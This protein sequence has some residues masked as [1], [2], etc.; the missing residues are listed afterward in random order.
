MDRCSSN[1]LTSRTP[2]FFLVLLNGPRRSRSST[3][4]ITTYTPTNRIG[5]LFAIVGCQCRQSVVTFAQSLPQ[6]IEM[7]SVS[8][9]KKSAVRSLELS[10]AA[11]SGV[12]RQANGLSW[13]VI[14]FALDVGLFI[15]F[16]FLC[17]TA[18]LTQFLFPSGPTGESW[19]LLGATVEGWRT[20][21]FWIL[22][23]FAI[24]V[25]IHV[26]LHW[27]WVCGV[28]E[29]RVLTRAGGK[30][31]VG[32]DGARTL[33]GVILLAATLLLLGIALGAAALLMQRTDQGL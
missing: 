23:V 17:W 6:M 27:S 5:L 25:L 21:Q 16:V 14:N 19:R 4:A 26:M 11:K 8:S 32:D 28:V 33:I 22:A 18:S 13:T 15:T 29:S 24:E 9:D 10:V 3:V 1:L 31:V 7:N 20:F 12:H 30:R 2:K